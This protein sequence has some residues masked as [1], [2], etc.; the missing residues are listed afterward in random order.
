MVPCCSNVSTKCFLNLPAYFAT[1]LSH[2][3]KS[4][5][6]QVS[7]EEGNQ[8]FLE[9]LNLF[10]NFF[11]LDGSNFQLPELPVNPPSS[12]VQ[13][14]ILLNFFVRNLQIFIAYNITKMINKAISSQQTLFSLSL[15]IR[16]VC[17][18][19]VRSAWCSIPWTY[20]VAPKVWLLK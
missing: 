8:H 2:T 1:A 5:I 4:F 16:C 10:L 14:S 9:F 20:T 3:G 12:R 17:P 6:N 19:Q 13:V 15:T 7:G 11:K 18:S